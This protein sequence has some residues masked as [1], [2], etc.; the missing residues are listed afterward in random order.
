[1][2]ARFVLWMLLALVIV[3]VIRDVE[4]YVS[5]RRAMRQLLTRFGE[6]FAREF[7]RP[8]RSHPAT[9]A[10]DCELRLSPGRSRIEGLLAPRNGRRYPNLTDHRK[11]VEYDISRVMEL[12]QN[13]P[14][15]QG[16][17]SAQGRWVVVPFQLKVN[18]EQAGGK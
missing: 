9:P 5:D 6:R 13:P 12:M 16:P 14:F 7:D 17:L 18:P 3:F 4:D 2:D 15:V 11:N 10:I 8:L 1:M